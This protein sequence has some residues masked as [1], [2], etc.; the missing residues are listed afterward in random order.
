MNTLEYSKYFYSSCDRE[1]GD[2]Q[3][4]YIGDTIADLSLYKDTSN[5]AFCVWLQIEQVG[6][7]TYLKFI[8]RSGPRILPL[9]ILETTESRTDKHPFILTYYV[10]E[11]R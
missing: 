6:L 8:K 11:D 1:C 3:F 2:A 9:G 5:P 4:L 10:L 7:L